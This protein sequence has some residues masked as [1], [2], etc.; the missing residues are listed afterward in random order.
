MFFAKTNTYKVK[1]KTWKQTDKPIVFFNPNRI[2]V[3]HLQKKKEEEDKGVKDWIYFENVMLELIFKMIQM[4]Y[5][6][7]YIIAVG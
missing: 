7:S 5:T 6:I 1:K 3:M 4:D 2:N